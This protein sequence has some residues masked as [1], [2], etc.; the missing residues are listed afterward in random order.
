MFSSRILSLA[1]ALVA[2]AVS[3][4]AAPTL[5]AGTTVIERQFNETL[6]KRD[7]GFDYGGSDIRGVNLG[8]WL[9]LGTFSCI[10]LVKP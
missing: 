9:L 3:T 6:S 7:T 1:S 10:R 4:N 5:K 8:G 2:A